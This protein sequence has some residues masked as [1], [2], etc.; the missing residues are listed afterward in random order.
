MTLLELTTWL[1][2]PYYKDEAINSH[3]RLLV[4]TG[5]CVTVDERVNRLVSE[6]P[7]SLTIKTVNTNTTS[8]RKHLLG[9]ECDIAVFSAHNGFSPGNFLALTG[10]IRHGGCLI[11][12]CPP[13]VN[14]YKQ[15]PFTDVSHGF[16]VSQSP[17]IK[18]FL[19]IIGSDTN[20]GIWDEANIHLPAL[21]KQCQSDITL[22]ASPP[23]KHPM[24]KSLEQQG[25][26]DALTEH[27]QNNSK[28]AVLTAPRGRGKS[29]LIG[30]FAASLVKNGQKVWVTSA[31]RENTISLFKQIEQRINGFIQVG[32]TSFTHQPS[33]GTISWLAPDNSTLCNEACDLLIVDEAASFPLPLLKNLLNRHTAWLMSTTLQGYEGSGLGFLHRMLPTLLEKQTN[34]ISLNSPLRWVNG[35]NLEKLINDLCLFQANEDNAPLHGSI[36]PALPLT[37]FAPRV[38]T[39]AEMN[40]PEIKQIMNLLAIAHYQTTPDDYLRL[41]DSPDVL[42]FSVWNKNALLGAAIINN[43]GGA[44][45]Q[46]LGEGIANGSRRPKG[47]LGAQR[48]TLMTTLPQTASFKYWRI[49]RIAVSPSLQGRGLGHH[50]INSIK[51]VAD[52]QYVDAIISSYGMTSKL[53]RFWQSN[54]FIMVDKGQKPNKASGETSALVLQGLTRAFAPTLHQL[55]QLYRA[56]LCQKVPPLDALEKETRDIFL[57]KLMQFAYGSRALPHTLSAIKSLLNSVR[58]VN[59]AILPA[60]K[61][62]PLRDAL[63]KKPLSENNLAVVLGSSGRKAAISELRDIT[64]KYIAAY[65]NIKSRQ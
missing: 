54:G 36:D 56:E 59:D 64:A 1:Y 40:E 37:A 6:A 45:L 11:L 50:I 2:S 35:D 31:I 60:N 10:T 30:I 26:F 3:R 61:Q 62:Q 52:Q 44:R 17:Y 55:K 13:F 4:I 28:T 57:T 14:W 39:L 41:L 38:S 29:S 32:K 63:N 16:T 22:K 5:D 9:N 23:T 21:V 12:C 33:G 18:R 24:F 58:N 48:L 15:A 49:N 20:I 65:T 51:Q 42:L 7:S 25:A 46:A 34:H 47:H 27:W 8:C 53:N 43:E 19:N